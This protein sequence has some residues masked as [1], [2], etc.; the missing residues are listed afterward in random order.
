[1]DSITIQTYYNQ[2]LD[3]IRKQDYELAGRS[4]QI[5]LDF[6]PSHTEANWAMG[7]IEAALGE[8]FKAL[9][10]WKRVSADKIPAVSEKINQVKEQL[11]RYEQSFA[12][13]NEGV[14]ASTNKEWARALECF[15]K[16]IQEA[17]DVPLPSSIYKAYILALLHHG[18]SEKGIA[19]LNDLP[20]FMRNSNDIKALKPLTEQNQ[21][22]P[23]VHE[24]KKQNKIKRFRMKPVLSLISGAVLASVVWAFINFSEQEIP[25]TKASSPSVSSTVEA[26]NRIALLEKR[27]MQLQSELE[28][29]KLEQVE[30]ELRV[31]QSELQAEQMEQLLNLAQIDVEELQGKAG[32]QAYKKGLESYQ[33]GEYEL[34]VSLLEKSQLL[35]SDM[36][37]SDDAA[38]YFIRANKQLDRNV[39]SFMDAFLQNTTPIFMESPYRDDLMLQV[40]HTYL[41]ESKW[42][43]ARSILQEIIETYP[44]EWTSEKATY[45]LQKNLEDTTNG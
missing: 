28:E 7:L 9:N 40:A 16:A 37:Y 24:Q 36:Y 19:F 14:T 27:E 31:E 12:M 18:E 39:E 41:E 13:Y 20:E 15:D 6:V 33:A 3:F 21:D 45:L 2:A 5:I 22:E 25:E 32:Y 10:R 43:K 42:S 8:P 44:L 17:G 30:A 11:A 34:A 29:A 1:M 23:H 35:V 26:D 38:Y 4:I